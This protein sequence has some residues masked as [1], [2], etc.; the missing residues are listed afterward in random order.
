MKS[1]EKEQETVQANYDKY[2]KELE[3]K[4]KRSSAS[5]DSLLKVNAE[6]NKYKEMVKGN[7]NGDLVINLSKNLKNE[8]SNNENLRAI[9]KAQADSIQLLKVQIKEL[10]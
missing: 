2:I 3:G 6:L 4:L 1:G 8:K 7:D 9:N 10:T 5:F